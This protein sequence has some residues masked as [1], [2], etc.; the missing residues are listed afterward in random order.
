MEPLSCKGVYPEG[1]GAD[2]AVCWKKGVDMV[3]RGRSRE[4]DCSARTAKLVLV[5]WPIW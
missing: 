2:W 3:S 5:T 4:R 1:G